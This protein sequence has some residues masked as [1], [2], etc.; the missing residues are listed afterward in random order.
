[1]NWTALE[2]DILKLSHKTKKYK[3][4]TFKRSDQLNLSSD[5]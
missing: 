2:S 4:D 5:W 1:M 3:A